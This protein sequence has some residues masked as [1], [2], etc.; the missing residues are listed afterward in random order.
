MDGQVTAFALYAFLRLTWHL[1]VKHS[2]LTLMDS[3]MCNKTRNTIKRQYGKRSPST[4]FTV[5]HRAERDAT[6]L[7]RTC[8]PI[9][10]LQIWTTSDTTFYC[11]IN[12]FCCLCVNRLNVCSL[13]HSL[14]CYNWQS[15]SLLLEL[16]ELVVKSRQP[17]FF[18]HS[19]M[20]F[21]FILSSAFNDGEL[22]LQVIVEETKHKCS[23]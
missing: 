13:S 8:R 22:L 7:Q 9:I 21:G 5:C 15:F 23:L 4:P 19:K 11:S 16:R 14:T 2:T 17:R 10:L 1:A 20:S 6:Y 18:A 12:V 3:R